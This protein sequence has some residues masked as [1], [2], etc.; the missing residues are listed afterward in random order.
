[1]EDT[2]QHK[3]QRNQ[4]VQN[5]SHKGINDEKVLAAI[6]EV[7]R[8]FF[9]DTAFAEHAY[10]DKPFPIGSGQTISQ[11]FTVA[12]QTQLLDVQPGE[13]VL[14][15]GTGSGYQAAVLAAMRARVYTIERQKELFRFS[16][17]IIGQMKYKRI[18][19]FYGDGYKGKPAYSPY[20]KILITCGAPFIPQDLIDQLKPGGYLVAP[21]GEGR[22][23]EM[24]RLI[25]DKD[26]NITT[27][28]H[29]SFSFVPMLKGSE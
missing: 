25:K 27:E 12:F 26:G 15:I 5:I 29:G 16:Q 7:P 4:L 17:Q 23:Q 10:E 3:G 11:P 2:F 14:E 13:K 1:M 21:V 24:K 8:H 22:V 28:N 20:D 6:G 19:F 18:Q 9:F